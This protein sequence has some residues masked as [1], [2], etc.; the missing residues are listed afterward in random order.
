[1]QSREDA[2]G[3]NGGRIGE[4]SRSSGLIDTSGAAALPNKE[5]N[6]QDL[7]DNRATSLV[8]LAAHAL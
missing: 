6:V 1:M 7:C 4:G 3:R 8:E 5:H 2:S